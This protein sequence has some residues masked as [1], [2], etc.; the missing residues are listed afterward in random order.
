[1]LTPIF[2]N[3]L[4]NPDFWPSLRALQTLFT[5]G[6][7]L[8][9]FF[10]RK[11]LRAGLRGELGQ[12]Y[13]TWLMLT[14][15]Y[16]LAAFAGGWLGAAVWLG[17]TGIAARE[18]VAVFGIT[19]PYARLLYTLIPL[20][21]YIAV[22]QPQ[23]FAALPIL[24][25]LLPGVVAILASRSGPVAEAQAQAAQTSGTY[26]YVVWSLGHVI[27]LQQLGGPGLTLLLGV[28]IALS[29]V[30]QYCVGKLFGRHVI[31]PSVS[32]NKAWEGMI[33]DLLG[34]GLVI[35]IFGFLAPAEFGLWPKVGLIIIVGLSASWGDL[36]SSLLKRAAGAKDWGALLPGH[37]GLLDRAN[38]FVVTMPL[39]YYFCC[40][41]LG[42]GVVV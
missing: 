40:T 26:L 30:M 8:V 37:G 10:A 41:V 31:A 36:F 11:N 24:A 33:G 7:G 3:P 19:R 27:L 25:M 14:P 35:G 38:S 17:A 32:P 12:R 5:L 22:A 34:A 1:M 23:L 29:D 42:H 4:L 6:A 21:L 15:L 2:N 28:A 16:L 18:A 13:L 39:A 20:T 9:I